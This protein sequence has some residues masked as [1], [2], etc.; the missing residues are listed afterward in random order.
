MLVDFPVVSNCQHAHVGMLILHAC[1]ILAC[2]STYRREGFMLIPLTESSAVAAL[3][4]LT[5]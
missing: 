1:V 3:T 4:D 5:M 2:L